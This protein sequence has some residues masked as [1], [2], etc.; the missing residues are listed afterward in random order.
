M[1]DWRMEAADGDERSWIDRCADDELGGRSH[2]RGRGP[3]D[4]SRDDRRIYEAVCERL[5]HDR[6]IDARGIEVEV[7]AAAVTLRGEARGAADPALARRLAAETP[8]VKDVELELTVN[9]N[10]PRFVGRRRAD[11]DEDWV[12]S[13]RLG[14]R[15][16]PT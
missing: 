10:S 8:G 3:Q 7:D 11:D 14:Y 4:W 9:P 16:V 2:H 13:S 6:L 5:L 15:I 1:S 12:D